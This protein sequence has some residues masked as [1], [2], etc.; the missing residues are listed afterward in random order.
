MSVTGDPEWWRG[1]KPPDDVPSQ[2]LSSR[3]ECITG[4][5]LGMLE[6]PEPDST[7]LRRLT[8]FRA[9]VRG[10]ELSLNDAHLTVAWS[11]FEQCHFRQRVRPVTN[12]QGF[13]A[14]GS[15]GAGPASYRGCTFERV[16]FKGMGG[17]S[18]GRARFEDCTFVNCRWEGHFAHDADL[19]DCTF[20]GRM[21]GCVWFGH[22]RDHDGSRRANVLRGNDFR[23]T[24][25]TDNVGWR[26]DFPIREQSWPVGFTPHV[27]VR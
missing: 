20:I 22:G 27:D 4:S 3:D 13:A 5:H 8:F 7:G 23:Q 25:F 26:S 19:V 12:G 18:L 21:N 6:T 10:V 2:W 14:Q 11:E 17:F 1:A 9:R 24:D 16:R 15:L